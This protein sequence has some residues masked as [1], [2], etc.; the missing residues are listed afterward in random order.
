MSKI[1]IAAA[2]PT[3]D[4]EAVKF[5][6]RRLKMSISGTQKKLGMGDK[7]LFYTCELFGNDHVDREKEIRDIAKFFQSRKIPLIYIEIRSDQNWGDIKTED[8]KKYYVDESSIINIL[9]ENEGQFE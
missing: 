8:L 2:N 5:L 9:D 7:G 4:M 6:H 3:S 1:S